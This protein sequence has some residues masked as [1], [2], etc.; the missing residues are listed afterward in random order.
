M[1]HVHTNRKGFTLIELIAVIV[2]LAI[3]AGVAL[4]KYFDYS[5]NAKTSACKGTLGGIRA[6]IKAFADGWQASKVDEND[7]QVCQRESHQNRPDARHGPDH[8]TAPAGL[9]QERKIEPREY[10]ER[11]QEIGDDNDD[12][13]QHGQDEGRP[14]L[15]L[16]AMR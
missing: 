7:G 8:N 4:P 3:L 2:V 13:G 6:G 14:A 15:G 12:D 1:N 16:L 9:G 5:A 11:H 10:D